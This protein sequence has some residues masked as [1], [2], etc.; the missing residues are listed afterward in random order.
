MV[1][2]TTLRRLGGASLLLVLSLS[3][4]CYS[5]E[6]TSGQR[7]QAG[8]AAAVACGDAYLEALESSFD[9]SVDTLEAGQ[10]TGLQFFVS[11]LNDP[12]L[13]TYRV[14]I[15]LPAEFT[16]NGFDALGSGAQI[17]RW[18]FEWFQADGTF[19]PNNIGFTIAEWAVDAHTAY[20]DSFVNGGYDAGVDPVATHTVG[21]GGEHRL[22]LILP[23]G[24]ADQGGNCTFFASD[25]RF[26]LF[27]GF[28][29]LPAQPGD[30]TVSLTATSVD[31][32]T[33]DAT[34]GQGTEP[35]TYLR[36]VVVTVVPEPSSALLAGAALLVVVALSRAGRS[37]G[38]RG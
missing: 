9:Y 37:M 27:G 35:S 11:T 17:G 28:F 30:Y 16:F 25:I 24:G 23:M 12:T 4:G 29:Q 38:R 33:G 1:R 14:D 21:G 15:T 32:D 2:W 34:D 20:A 3:P 26:T 8:V 5:G 31:P 6:R 18:E 7:A 36:D 22:A 10:S 13:E 19:D